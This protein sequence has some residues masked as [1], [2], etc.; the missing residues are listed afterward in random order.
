MKAVKS[1]RMPR[2]N[3]GIDQNGLTFLLAAKALGVSFEATATIG[4]QRLFFNPRELRQRLRVA[5]V[6]LSVRK[7]YEVMQ[8]AN[9]YAEPCL[10]LL[11][12]SNIS[13]LDVSAYEGATVIQD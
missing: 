1:G 13:S 5:G 9:G 6:Q 12:A 4:H 3:M 2:V 7:A 10:S 11:G 8:S